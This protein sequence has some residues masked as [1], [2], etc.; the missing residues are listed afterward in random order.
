MGIATFLEI[1]FP[2]LAAG[3]AALLVG[4]RANED[5]LLL[6]PRRKSPDMG[7]VLP[8]RCRDWMIHGQYAGFVVEPIDEEGSL[9]GTVLV[10][11]GNAGTAEGRLPL[12]ARFASLGYRAVVVEYPGFGRRSGRPSLEGALEACKEAF[13]AATKAWP[14]ALLLLGESLGAGMAGQV[15]RGNET[16]VAAA[17]FATP[18]DSLSAVA[19]AKLRIV[20]VDRLL[21][22]TFDTAAVV[23]DYREPVV[24]IASK[25]DTLIPVRH[26]RNLARAAQTGILLELEAGHNDWYKNMSDAHW[27]DLREMMLNRPDVGA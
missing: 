2:A 7:A 12:A 27:E 13:H 23:S 14:G 10:F 19:R 26:A 18:W 1:A 8:H 11:H 4:L 22:F 20:P 15:L 25:D 5:R 3:Y 16:R 9:S 17:I 6:H 24:V 21:R